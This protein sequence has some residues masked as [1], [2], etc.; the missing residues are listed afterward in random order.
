MRLITPSYAKESAEEADRR[1]AEFT[2]AIV[3]VLAEFL[4]K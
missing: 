1:L 4:P 2:R 3:L